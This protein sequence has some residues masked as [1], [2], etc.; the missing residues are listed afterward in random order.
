MPPEKVF[1]VFVW[2]PDTEPR[3]VFGCLRYMVY[4]GIHWSQRNLRTFPCA[5]VFTCMDC[6]SKL[7]DTG[8]GVFNA[9]ITIN[10]GPKVW[11]RRPY[12]EY[13]GF[14]T[15]FFSKL[16]GLAGVDE[17]SW[18]A[19]LFSHGGSVIFKTSIF[20]F[21]LLICEEGSKE[22]LYSN[23]PWDLSTGTLLKP[24]WCNQGYT[25]NRIW[26]TVQGPH[27]MANQHNP[28]P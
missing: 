11:I 7:V 21:L 23:G 1:K 15:C 18:S 3:E 17:H 2:G 4:W 22:S 19:M 24:V 12:I 26:A 27:I 28:P 10:Y 16:T 25:I 13:L 14:W 5:K 9:S 20:R 6:N 8:A